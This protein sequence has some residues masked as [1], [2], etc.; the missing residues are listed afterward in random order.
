M[1]SR[2]SGLESSPLALNESLKENLIHFP[3]T[4]LK[5][6]VRLKRKVRSGGLKINPFPPE[7]GVWS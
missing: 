1:Y 5:S 4:A 7:A 3:N 6:E 2:E